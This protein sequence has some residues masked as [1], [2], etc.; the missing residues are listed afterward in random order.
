MTSLAATVFD[1]NQGLSPYQILATT[2]LW[3]NKFIIT[4]LLWD[5]YNCFYK[6]WTVKSI[7]DF[8][9]C[10][11][12]ILQNASVGRW[13]ESERKTTT[14]NY[15]LINGRQPDD[16]I[17]KRWTK[18]FHRIIH[19]ISSFAYHWHIIQYCGSPDCNAKGRWL[20]TLVFCWSRL[21]W[22]LVSM[23]WSK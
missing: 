10:N 21:S 4:I 19:P 2:L 3:S 7:I 23:E 22:L 14:V 18:Y 15:S 1:C 17:D 11:L 9:F 6:M 13:S 16:L 20:N 12:M 8:F 5:L